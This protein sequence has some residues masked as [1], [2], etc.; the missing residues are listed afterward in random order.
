MGGK[1]GQQGSLTV[2]FARR[3]GAASKDSGQ[4]Q[5]WQ[6]GGLFASG[7]RLGSPVRSGSTHAGMRARCPLSSLHSWTGTVESY[8]HRG[9][10]KRKWL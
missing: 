10:N 7:A 8:G 6:E 5:A 1:Q 3:A 2:G 9:E 4:A